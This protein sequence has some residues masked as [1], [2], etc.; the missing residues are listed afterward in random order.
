MEMKPQLAIPVL[1]E[2][3]KIVKFRATELQSWPFLARIWARVGLRGLI[4]GFIFC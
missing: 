2:G 4:G 1:L 3:S